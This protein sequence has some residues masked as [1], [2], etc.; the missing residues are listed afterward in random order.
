[1]DE[2]ESTFGTFSLPPG[3]RSLAGLVM[4]GRD[5]MF[6]RLAGVD[7]TGADLYWAS[8]QSCV[9]EGAILKCCCLRG[10][11]LEEANLRGAD[12]RGADLSLDNLGGSTRLDR[13]DLSGADL[14]DAKIGGAHF[15][16]AI[17][18]KADLR[19]A[20]ARSIFP[21]RPTRFDG[22][23]L[24]DARLG[25]ADLSGCVFDDKTRFPHAFDPR[26]A[27]MVHADDQTGRKKKR[28]R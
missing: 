20:W 1:M 13:A 16:R 17:L 25:G 9:L 4:Q 27:G 6:A 19:S 3:D 2:D 15:V 26:K 14:R 10:A 21:D 5:L 24:T 11:A 22:A 23:D 18:V 8:L 28:K 7:L 12:M